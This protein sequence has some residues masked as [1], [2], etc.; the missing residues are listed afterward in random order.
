LISREKLPKWLRK[1]RKPTGS[2]KSRLNK[3]QAT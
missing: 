2:K 1:F 3:K